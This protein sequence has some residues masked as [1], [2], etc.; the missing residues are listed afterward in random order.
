MRAK[1]FTQSYQ[2]NK[3]FTLVEIIIGI[4]VFALSLSVITSLILPTASQSANQLQQI[5]AAELAQSLMNEIIGRS[6]DENSD[7]VG[8]QNRC[9]EDLPSGAANPCTVSGSFGPDADEGSR[10]D[11]DDVDD[12]NNWSKSGEFI[13]NAEG[14][15]LGNHYQGF[16]VNVDV[17]YDGNY[18]GTADALQVA[19][20][21]TITVTS[22]SKDE[23]VFSSYK[24][25]F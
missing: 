25:N 13:E 17:V 20:L 2:R 9:D 6:F 16:S 14:V 11:F 18:D 12:Y 23:I 3:G 4:V 7:R 22:P 10:A 24:A 1:P 21:I 8:G 15:A 19:K 5:R